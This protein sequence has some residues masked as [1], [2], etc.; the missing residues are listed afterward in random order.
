VLAM[1]YKLGLNKILGTIH[2][3][4]TMVEANKYAAGDWK[5]ANK[6]EKLLGW[7]EK[8]HDWRRG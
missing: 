8:Y 2:A 3:Y 1:K 7:V 5:R 6:P 4:P